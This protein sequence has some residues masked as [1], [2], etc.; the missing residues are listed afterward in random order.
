[1]VKTTEEKDV[2]KTNMTLNTIFCN[3]TL[4][5]STIR[6]SSQRTVEQ[7][8]QRRSMLRVCD[9]HKGKDPLGAKIP[10]LVRH[11]VSEPNCRKRSVIAKRLRDCYRASP[12]VELQ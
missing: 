7:L 8:G 9:G 11:L 12:S 10:A 6:L 2:V 5:K 4:C 3:G 1:M